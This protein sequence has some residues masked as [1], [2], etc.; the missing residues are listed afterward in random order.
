MREEE[1]R[2]VLVM[3]D[4]TSVVIEVNANLSDF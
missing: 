3:P 4:S 1:I 2:H